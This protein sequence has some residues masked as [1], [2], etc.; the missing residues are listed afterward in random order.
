MLGAETPRTVFASNEV[1]SIVMPP[2]SSTREDRRHSSLRAL[3]DAFTDGSYVTIAE[4]PYD[5]H[6]RAIL[7]R[8]DPIAEEIWDFRCLDPNPG[9][10]A[11]GCFSETDT[12]IALTWDYRENIDD[13]PGEV[14]RC[15]K[16]W[17]RLFCNLSPHKGKKL[18][19]YVSYNFR[20]V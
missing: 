3:F 2:W 9:I 14:D 1:A 6:A 19:E 13:W 4:D 11:F 18:N 17:K 7:A 5:K 15:K 20:A 16:E 10:R 12:F 8:V